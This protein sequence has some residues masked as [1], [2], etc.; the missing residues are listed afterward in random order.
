MAQTD[1]AQTEQSSLI[2]KWDKEEG[3]FRWN[4]LSVKGYNAV[5]NQ[6]KGMTKQILF[7]SN[8]NLP[9]VLR[10]FEAEPGGHSALERHEHVH[11]VL[12]L[13]GKGWILLGDTVYPISTND[14]IYIPPQT[15][16]QFYAPK[17]EHLGFLCIVAAERDR[18]ARPTP[19]EVEELKKNPNIADWVR[20]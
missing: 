17:D 2:R 20:A 8:E 1:M 7:E 13:R 9:S 10:Y 19:E 6:S 15:W 14:T 5:G 3:A 18:P 11:A 12:I 4:G 16:H